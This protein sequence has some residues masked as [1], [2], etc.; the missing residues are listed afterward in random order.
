MRKAPNDRTLFECY[1]RFLY[2][3]LC[4]DDTVED[5]LEIYFL[6]GWNS[7][8]IVVVVPRKSFLDK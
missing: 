7:S 4:P 1:E 2:R 6:E 5:L 8:W 3:H